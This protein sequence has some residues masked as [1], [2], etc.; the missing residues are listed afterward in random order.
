MQ[1][2]WKSEGKRSLLGI[3]VEGASAC[4]LPESLFCAR[5][6]TH[7]CQA[8]LFRYCHTHTHFYPLCPFY[9]STTNNNNTQ[10]QSAYHERIAFCLNLHNE[11]VK[12]MRFEPDAHKRALAAANGRK[13]PTAEEIA[14]ESL[15]GLVCWLV[16]WL[17]GLFCKSD[18][19]AQVCVC[20]CG[21]Q[22]T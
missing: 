19:R 14:R 15:V 11:A 21:K 20:L 2:S 8:L 5:V 3:A 17:V 6:L 7:I 12:A 16:V 18:V 9:T 22:N 4:I 13:E 1:G 10:Q